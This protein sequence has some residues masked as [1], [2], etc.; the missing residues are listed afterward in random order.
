MNYE[1]INMAHKY[2]LQIDTNQIILILVPGQR[3]IMCIFYSQLDTS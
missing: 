2:K 1:A 3:M